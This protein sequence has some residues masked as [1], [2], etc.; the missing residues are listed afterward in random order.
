MQAQTFQELLKKYCEAI[1]ADPGSV[2]MTFD[3]DPLDLSQTPMDLDMDD[4]DVVD[5]ALK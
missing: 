2:T 5:A 1:G 3:G 4:D